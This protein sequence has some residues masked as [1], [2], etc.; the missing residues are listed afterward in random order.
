VIASLAATD[1]GD[2]TAKEVSINDVHRLHLQQLGIP[3]EQPDG[4]A[5]KAVQ[6]MINDNEYQAF[7]KRPLPPGFTGGREAHF[8]DVKIDNELLRGN[9]LFQ[10]S[11]FYFLVDPSPRGLIFRFRRSTTTPLRGNGAVPHQRSGGDVGQAFQPDSVG[12]ESPTYI[13]DFRGAK[14]GNYNWWARQLRTLADRSL[15]HL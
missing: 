15:K 6:A 14:G 5:D 10:A 3:M 2:A 9:S 11:E 8:L 4:P 7:R 12:L 13:V 1:E